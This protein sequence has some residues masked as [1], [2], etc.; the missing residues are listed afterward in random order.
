MLSL[1]NVTLTYPDGD[2]TLRA[3]DNASIS[4]QP[5]EMTAISGPSGSGKSS[6]LAIASTLI[7]PDTGTVQISE[8]NVSNLNARERTTVRKNEL[9]IVFQAPN[10]I[11]SLTVRE[12]LEVMAR[13]G[14]NSLSGLTKPELNTRIDRL[15]E[16][17]GMSDRTKFLPEK[18]SGGQR[19]RVN[20]ARGLIHK[21]KVLIVDE[22]TSALDSE[23]SQEIFELLATLTKERE[24]A[25]LIVTH[26]IEYVDYC[27][28]HYHM[29]DG[30]LSQLE[31][32]R[33]VA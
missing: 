22:P 28:S 5:G 1:K 3:V 33:M 7:H 30:A 31:H 12:Q 6:L 27:D 9:G 20:I 17:V 2:T 24:L 11:A 25:T 13:I 16:E 10:L 8:I 4:V 19:Q 15:L 29:A 14:S 32:S 18:L 26:D 21:P 23:R